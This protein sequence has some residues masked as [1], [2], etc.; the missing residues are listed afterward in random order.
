MIGGI[1]VVKHPVSACVPPNYKVTLSVQAKGTGPLSYQ[2]FKSNKGKV[3]QETGATQADLVLRPE[4]SQPYVCRVS[5]QYCN[6]AFTDWVKVK[7][8]DNGT[9][10][11]LPAEWD[12]EPHMTLHPNP[13]TV[14]LGERFTLTCAAFGIPPPTHQWYRNGQPLQGETTDTLQIKKAGAEHSGS[15]LCCVSN[16]NGETWTEAADVEVVQP[17]PP[18]ASELRATDKVAL[19]IGNLNYSHHPDLMA[20]TM[21]VHKLAHLLLELDF[22]VVSLLDLSRAEMDA[23]IERFLQLLVKGVYAIFYYA[24][25]G[26]ENSGRN[27]LVPVDAPRPYCTGNCVCVQRVMQRMQEQQAVLSVILLDTCRKWYKQNPTVSEIKPL[28]PLGNTVYGYATC[29]DAEAFEV[30]DGGRSTGIFTKYLNKHIRLREKVTHVLELVSE[31]LGKDPLVFGRQVVEIKHTLKEP[32]SLTDPIQTDGHTKELRLRD[33]FWREAN[34]LPGRKLLV[35]PCGVKVELSF[36]ALFSNVLVV[37]ATVKDMGPRAKDC[38]VNLKSR[39]EM[40]DILSGPDR[41]GEMDSLLLSIADKPD[42]SLRLCSL[43][44]LQKP[45]E[46]KTDLHYTDSES[47]KRLIESKLL[48]IGLPLV[49]SCMLNPR[50][51]LEQG[52]SVLSIENIPWCRQAARQESGGVVRPFTRKA[53]NLWDNTRV[54]PSACSNIPEENDENEHQDFSNCQ[55]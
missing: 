11:E 26:Y 15:Y 21:D 9:S 32:R 23:A 43:Q 40:E 53:E 24:G 10:A 36:S 46:I 48:D 8:L 25:H 44:K 33:A 27:Y 38:T 42:C 39:P 17:D 12:G 4:R 19:L 13:Q 6:C 29:E 37:F 47:R 50:M 45:L 34:V 20:P 22:R 51:Q 30:Q 3:V 52:P 54:P 5:D 7:V 1:V 41:S 16:V 14:M 31:D 35:F 49:A 2:W 28:A 18:Q 55:F